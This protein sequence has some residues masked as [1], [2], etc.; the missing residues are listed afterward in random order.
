M[1][2]AHTP[3]A[4]LFVVQGVHE[5]SDTTADRLQHLGTVEEVQADSPSWLLRVGR[6]APDSRGAWAW[7]RQ[8]LAEVLQPLFAEPVL[9]DEKGEPHLPTGEV[10]LRFQDVP[11]DADLAAFAEANGLRLLARN[12]YVLEKAVYL[13]ADPASTY[14]PDLVVQ[15]RKQRGVASAWANTRSRYRRASV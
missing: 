5:V 8:R 9:L 2:V 12:P 7:L 4:E 14:I 13:L 15:L 11:S 1:P 6:V 10:T 3:S